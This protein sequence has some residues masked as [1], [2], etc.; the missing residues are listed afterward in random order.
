MYGGHANIQ[1]EERLSHSNSNERSGAV[2]GS[3]RV[4]A[5]DETRVSSGLAAKRSS[6]VLSME[7]IRLAPNHE[8]FESLTS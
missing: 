7:S 1:S 6:A 3:G 2:T 5:A 4:R 8:A